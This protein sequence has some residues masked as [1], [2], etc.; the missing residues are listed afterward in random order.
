MR[1]GGFRIG[2]STVRHVGPALALL[3]TV[4]GCGRDGTTAAPRYQDQDAAA[5]ATRLGCEDDDVRQRAVDALA[6]GGTVAAELLR[7][8][9]AVDEN[10]RDGGRA[11]LRAATMAETALVRIGPSAHATVVAALGDPRPW[12][13]IH[14]ASAVGRMHPAP[15]D[16]VGPLTVNLTHGDSTV[17]TTSARALGGLE[18]KSAP[19]VEAL[20]T[21]LGD[22]DRH[23]REAAATA[24]AGIG[25]P[26]ATA[27]HD[28][29][30]DAL[31]D[32]AEDVRA[33]AVQ[34][35]AAIG[36]RPEALPKLMAVWARDDLAALYVPDVLE[37][38][39]PEAAPAL[40]KLIDALGAADWGRRSSAASVLGGLGAIAAAAVDPL[41]LLLDDRVMQPRWSAAEALG[42]IGVR[43]DA[44]LERLRALAKGDP[45]EEV[46]TAAQEALKRLAE[47]E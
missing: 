8:I 36:P 34:A 18:T 41:L 47:L 39:G 13:R 20:A 38:M 45:E 5:W 16:A 23:A 33:A 26:A 21:L 15:V 35:L 10:A 22:E 11:S 42:R 14:A 28:R 1:R 27:A 6:A 12:A 29:L 17:R 3:L 37:A 4:I 32:G 31:Q 9:I 2:T 19:A 30:V 24:L 25:G 44:V 7:S 40:P 43:K 46:K